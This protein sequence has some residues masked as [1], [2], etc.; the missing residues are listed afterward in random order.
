[1]GRALDRGF[2]RSDDIVMGVADVDLAQPVRENG[3]KGKIAEPPTVLDLEPRLDEQPAQG[4]IG[5]DHDVPVHLAIHQCLGWLF[6]QEVIASM[7]ILDHRQV[8]VGDR[9]QIGAG[10]GLVAEHEGENIGPGGQVRAVYE[11]ESSWLED[12]VDL[13]DKLPG[14]H[15][16]LQDVKGGDDIDGA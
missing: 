11:N 7:H 4:S 8:R 15:Q 5:R 16:V 13:A 2:T 3:G 14:L 12:P 6:V 1:M 10:K 9:D